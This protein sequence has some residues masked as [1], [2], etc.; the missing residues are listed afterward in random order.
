MFTRPLWLM[1]CGPI[2]VAHLQMRGHLRPNRCTRRV[3]R[4]LRRQWLAGL[5]VWPWISVLA[6]AVPSQRMASGVSIS[7]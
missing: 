6:C 2:S 1:R 4:R 3:A 5:W 7:A